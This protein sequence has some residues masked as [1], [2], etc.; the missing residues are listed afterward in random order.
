MNR[1]A[2][3][4]SLLMMLAALALAPAAHA[5]GPAP[6]KLRVE[7]TDGGFKPDTIEAQQGQMVELTFVWAQTAHPNDEHI[8]VVDGYH[9]ESD[10]IDSTHRETTVKFIAD[11]AGTFAFRCDLDC[12]AHDFLQAGHLKVTAG[13]SG[14]TAALTPTTLSVSPSS[15]VTPGDPIVLMV[16]LRDNQG[17]PVSKAPVEFSLDAEFGGVKGAMNIGEA[18]TDSN[19]VAF[20][21]YQ[22]TVREVQQNITAQFDGMGTYGESKQSVQ[23]RLIATPPSAY[24][25]PPTGLP[26]T[27]AY[28]SLTP[29]STSLSATSVVAWGLTHW[30]EVPL[31][32]LVG[33]V[34]LAFAYV[35]WQALGVAWVRPRE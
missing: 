34:W 13:G 26:G 5:Q 29:G 20:L 3:I 18:K 21:A 22:P 7:V 4:A 8:M 15:W 28:A 12:E 10:K 2:I 9:L 14:G 11:K 31:V 27:P 16:V 30:Q 24:Q 19:G 32:L 33:G 35:V 1:R 6:L 25:A 17:A 23:L